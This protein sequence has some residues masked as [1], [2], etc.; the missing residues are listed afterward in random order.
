MI[1]HIPHSSTTIPD[2]V[3][4]DKEDIS[5]DL[6]R[7]TDTDTDKLFAYSSMETII[8]PYS[9]LFCDVERFIDN[10]PMDERG[11]G[12]CYTKDSFGGHLRNVTESEREMIINE[13]YKPHHLNLTRACNSALS[14]FNT[15]V[16]VDCHSFSNEVQ[17]QD[18]D[19]TS[20]RPDFCIGTDAFH[21]PN[22]LVEDIKTYLQS[23]GFSVKINSPFSGTIVPLSHY[24]KTPNL[25]SIMIEVNRNLYT[26][27]FA[28]TKQVVDRILE[29]INN[30]E[31]T[32]A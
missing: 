11:H 24:Q 27:S 18:F 5:Q 28:D 4:F 3:K 1:L 6:L 16:L 19:K 26:K 7:L 21:T 9:R 29:I 22:D 10:E 31:M 23:K 30:Y 17:P 25:K 20:S 8:F 15:V 14:L 12:I 2:W 32:G 13:Y